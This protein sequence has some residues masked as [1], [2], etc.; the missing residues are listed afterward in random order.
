LDCILKSCFVP[1][2]I[3]RE[4]TS[5]ALQVLPNFRDFP[6]P[7]HIANS[8]LE[9]AFQCFGE[10]HLLCELVV[11]GSGA[12]TRTLF[13]Q[14][15]LYESFTAGAQAHLQDEFSGDWAK[16]MT[17]LSCSLS[18]FHLEAFRRPYFTELLPNSL[19]FFGAGQNG[20]NLAGDPQGRGPHYAP[21]APPFAVQRFG[22]A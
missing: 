11:R 22:L 6:E 15:S 18:S 3:C 8:P 14:R 20:S 1:E 7:G 10:K 9:L 16:F 5:R 4:A 21:I 17:S 2:E 13:A 19:F 12:F